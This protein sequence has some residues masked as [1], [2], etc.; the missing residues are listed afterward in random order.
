MTVLSLYTETG[1]P[2]VASDTKKKSGMSAVVKP[3]TRLQLAT[4]SAGDILPARLHWG[5]WAQVLMH[6]IA[7]DVRMIMLL[8][9]IL[10]PF[11]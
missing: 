9:F 4:Q 3:T 5:T 7:H 8:R 6:A 11:V 1:F 10:I 2:I